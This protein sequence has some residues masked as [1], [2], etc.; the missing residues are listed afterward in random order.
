MLEA[1]KAFFA[2]NVQ[3]EPAP[4]EP[5]EVKEEPPVDRIAIAAC[6]LM[7]ELAHADREF[8]RAEQDHIHEA[9]MRHFDLPPDTAREL[10]ALADQERQ[11]AVD[12][13]QFTSL[14]TEHY[15]EGQRMVLAEV[16]WRLVYSDGQLAKHEDYLMRK[17][18]HLLDLKPAYLATAKRRA[19]VRGD[20]PPSTRTTR[21]DAPD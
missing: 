8:S 19:A 20:R 2:R 7:L 12:L 10:M 4:S 21:T 11:Q 16:L 3:L 17:L 13:F 15:D 14:I 6:A 18:A 5:L 9:L 1:I